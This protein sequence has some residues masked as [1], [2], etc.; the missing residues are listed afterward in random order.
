[1]LDAFASGFLIFT[2]LATALFQLAIVFGAP[3][4]KYSYGGHNKG[5][6]SLRYRIISAFASLVMIGVA[7][8]Y[9]AQLGILKPL[10]GTELNAIAN[11]GFAGFALLVAVVTSAF[12]SKKERGFWSPIAIA[13]FLAALIVAF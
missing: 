6:P 12:G 1:M 8:H 3:L 4:M 7:G 5:S 2:Y 9:V 11:W 13:M 10:L